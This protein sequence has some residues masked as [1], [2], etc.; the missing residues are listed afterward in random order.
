[1]DSKESTISSSTYQTAKSTAAPTATEQKF[2]QEPAGPVQTVST[3]PFNGLGE[4]EFA[5][6]FRPIP[7]SEVKPGTPVV[8]A[9][10]KVSMGDINSTTSSPATLSN[11]LNEQQMAALYDYMVE[12]CDKLLN[13]ELPNSS[14]NSIYTEHSS[15]QPKHK[16]LNTEV[17]SPIFLDLKVKIKGH[18][19]AVAFLYL[20]SFFNP[21]CLNSFK[22]FFITAIFVIIKIL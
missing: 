13:N 8:N 2:T 4:P 14:V 10:P 22:Y 1:M 18:R 5:K 19:S 16:A 12:R 9:L 7:F 17:K 15:S 20:R 21:S 6:V 3:Q 11:Q